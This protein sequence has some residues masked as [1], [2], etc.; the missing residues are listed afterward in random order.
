VTK[1][2]PSS[3]TLVSKM[4]RRIHD[5]TNALPSRLNWEDLLAEAADEIERL[6][7]KLE[8]METGYRLVQSQKEDA[9]R[10]IERLQKDVALLKAISRGLAA[11]EPDEPRYRYCGSFGCK[12][13]HDTHNDGKLVEPWPPVK[14]KDG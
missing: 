11:D 10:E 6:N 13:N 5:A 3:K 4:R 12:G 2:T 14:T 7:G 9:D 8:F 1:E